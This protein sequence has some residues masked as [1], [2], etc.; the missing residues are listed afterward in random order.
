MS[1]KFK[2][3]TRWKDNELKCACLY[4]NPGCDR[5][6][7][8]EVL[9]FSLDPYA[10]VEEVMKERSYRRNKGSLKQVRSG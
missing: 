2:F 9:E 3:N 7:T 6:K 4:G 5:F 1:G 10:D 8:C